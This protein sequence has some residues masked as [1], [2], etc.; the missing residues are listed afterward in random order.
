[1]YYEQNKTL[2]QSGRQNITLRFWDMN[3]MLPASKKDSKYNGWDPWVPNATQILQ[4]VD[5]MYSDLRKIDYS[6]L[7]NACVNRAVLAGV[8]V[9][10]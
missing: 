9:L 5:D 8:A 4:S 7:K 6:E 3:P 1:M 10:L 2:V